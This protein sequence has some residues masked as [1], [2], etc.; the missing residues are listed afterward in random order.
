MKAMNT[1]VVE[2]KQGQRTEVDAYGK[3]EDK[4]RGRTVFECAE[5]EERSF[6]TDN[7][8]KIE[9]YPSDPDGEGFRQ[10]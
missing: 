6:P 1:Y 10:W 3:R 2:F 4:S 5:G 9:E 8:E 7:I